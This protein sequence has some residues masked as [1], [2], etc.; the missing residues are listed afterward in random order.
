M[1]L[2]KALESLNKLQKQALARRLSEQSLATA[3]GRGNKDANRKIKK[4]ITEANGE[5]KSDQQKDLLKHGKGKLVSGQ[6]FTPEQMKKLAEGVGHG[7][8]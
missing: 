6:L 5:M 7:N 2:Y 1:S 4:A 8:N 3:A